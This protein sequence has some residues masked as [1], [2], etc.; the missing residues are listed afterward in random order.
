[1]I[2]LDTRKVIINRI[3]ID[4]GRERHGLVIIIQKVTKIQALEQEIRKGLLKKGFVAKTTLQI[5]RQ[6]RYY[7]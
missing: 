1:M 6:K 2:T 5:F 4:E 3:P 7:A